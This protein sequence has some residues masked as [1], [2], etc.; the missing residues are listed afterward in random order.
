MMF[1]S[2]NFPRAH[3]DKNLNYE[4]YYGTHAT[5]YA[6][7]NVQTQLKSTV[8]TPLDRNF[9]II[10]GVAQ[11]QTKRCI[12]TTKRTVSLKLERGLALW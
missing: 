7:R 8:A 1:E 6:I 4:Y 12:S 9:S 5:Q 10:E 3:S 11:S 2:K